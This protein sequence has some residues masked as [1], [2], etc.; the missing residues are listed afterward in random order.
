[1]RILVRIALA[2]V[3]LTPA[4]PA[5]TQTERRLVT[6]AVRVDARPFVWKDSATGQYLGFFWDICTDA[7]VRA[8][9]DFNAVDVAAPA[10]SR[11]LETGQGSFD[12][13]CDPT[14]ITLSRMERFT[15]SNLSFSPIVFVANG[16]HVTS[17][18][19]ERG[20]FAAGEDCDTVAATGMSS[21]AGGLMPASAATNDLEVIRDGGEDAADE[22]LPDRVGVLAWLDRFVALRQPVSSPSENASGT[23]EVWGY[24]E[25]TTGEHAVHADASARSDNVRICSRALPSHADAAR[26]FCAGELARYY[27]DVEIVQT[28]INDE[29]NRARTT[30][31]ARAAKIPGTYEPYAFVVSATAHP[32]LPELFSHALY[33]MFGDGSI[34]RTFTGHFPDTRKS[35]FLETLFRINAIPAR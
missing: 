18:E 30:C 25:G 14:T 27:G 7:V 6:I 13:L 31:E 2:A 8:G 9:Y 35:Q 23:Y 28:A 26:A 20:T 29:R 11:F 19:T 16:S 3:L 33:G 32:D 24:V 15:K 34:E 17:A 21:A 10:R 22:G 4:L 12:L 1:M 5:S